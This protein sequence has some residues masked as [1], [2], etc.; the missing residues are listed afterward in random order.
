MK[1]FKV[2]EPDEVGRI[3]SEILPFRGTEILPLG[4][5]SGRI[6]AKNLYSPEN[7]PEYDRSTV[8]G[9]AVAAKDVYGASESVPSLL[10]IIG[11]VKMGE[12]DEFKIKRGE[13]V[14]VP[15][16]GEV[17]EGADCVVP[18]EYCAETKGEAAVYRPAVVGE[19]VIRIGED[20]AKGAKILSEGGR[21]TV[22]AIGLLAALGFAE[23]EVYKRRKIAVVSTGDEIT[24]IA[25]KK[26]KGE[27]RDVNTHVIRALC[28]ENNCDITYAARVRDDFRLLDGIVAEALKSA[29]I[30]L[31][32][33][34]SSVG[35]RDFTE[36]VFSNRGKILVHGVAVKPGKPTIIA[37]A[38]DGKMLVGLPGNPTACLFVLKLLI[39]PAVSGADADPF[40]FAKTSANFPSSPGRTT[41]QPVSVEFGEEEAYASPVFCKSGYVGASVRADGYVLIPKNAEGVGMGERVKVYLFK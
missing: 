1:F 4:E 6:S 7:L 36:R 30:I 9:Y 10:K 3:I 25:A 32:S 20:M 24:D 33:G 13:T 19:N 2:S 16:G 34:G 37:E 14:R 17:P 22:S 31:V 12:A 5:A 18:L 38:P 15:T 29:E 26:R 35:S 28:E 27:I 21:V 23:I 11:G 39:L 40:V 8:D 41:V